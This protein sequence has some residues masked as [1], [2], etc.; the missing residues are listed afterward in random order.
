MFSGIRNTAKIWSLRILIS[1]S[2]KIL[3]DILRSVSAK[4]LFAFFRRI[5]N[6]TFR[7]CLNNR[8]LFGAK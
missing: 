8:A 4:N 3:I 6:P 1:A 5:R 7:S 2:K